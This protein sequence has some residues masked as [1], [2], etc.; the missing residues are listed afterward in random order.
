[1]ECP[2]CHK[3]IPDESTVCPSCHK[4]LSL[5]CP[6]CRTVGHSSVCDN[7][8]Y[9]I[10]ERCSKCGHTVSTNSKKCKCGFQVLTSIA[11]QE[12]EADEFA[13]VTVNF[14]GLKQVRKSLASKELFDKFKIKLK[15]LLISQFKNLDGNV[16]S[17]GDTYVIN[18]NKELSFQTSSAKAV[19]TALKLVNAFTSLNMKVIE[20]FGVLLKMHLTIIKKSAEELLENKKYKTNVKPLIINK[21]E[22]KYLRGTQI[23]LDEFVQDVISKEYKTDSLYTVEENGKTIVFYEIKLDN[24]VL[25][26]DKNIEEVEMVNQEKH[27]AI[28]HSDNNAD[29]NVN[30][31][32]IFD[33]KAKCNFQNSASIDVLSKLSDKNIIA[34]KGSPDLELETS[35]IV[36]YYR[37][38]GRKVLRVVCTEE[39]NYRPWGVLEEIFRQ[40]YNLS[41]YNKLIP[42]DL[43][44]QYFPE[45]VNLVQ[46]K[47]RKASTPEDARFAYIDDFVRF[48]SIIKDT[49]VIIDGFEHADDTTLQAIELYFDNY[50]KVK[51]NFI[52]ITNEEISVHSKI[53]SLL[54]TSLYKEINLQKNK[55]ENLISDIKDD[56][57]DFI[58]SF[59]YE[60]IKSCFKGSKL[61]FDNAINYLKEHD[62]LI[63]FEGKLLVKNNDSVFLPSELSELI[64]SRLK[65]LSK[66]Q[67]ASMVLAF[68]VLINPR[69][70]YEFLQLLGIQDL[71]SSLKILEEAGFVY[72][73]NNCVFLNNAPLFRSVIISSLKKNVTEFLSKTILA[74]VGQGLDN[75]TTL[76][77][78]GKIGLLKDEYLLLWK[79]A[80]FAIDTG[81]YD[82][83]LKNTM[84]FMKLIDYIKGNIPD[85][86]IENH[87]KDVYNNILSALFSYS[88]EKIYDIEQILI[89]DAEKKDDK[90]NLVK[91]S[92]LMLQGALLSGKFSDASVFLNNIFKNMQNPKFLV[93]GVINTKFLLLSLINIEISFNLG[94]Y[95]SCIDIANE[96]LD[97]LTPEI[98]KKIKPVN[99]SLNL[100]AEHL[101]ETFRLAAIAH[102]LSSGNAIEVFLDKIKIS[103]GEE[104]PDKGSLIAVKNF[105]AGKDYDIEN[106]E[107]APAFSK[108]IYLILQEFSEQNINWKNFAQNIYQAKLLASDINQ[109]MLKEFCE[110]LIAY[111]YAK[112]EVYKKAENIFKDI[113][114]KS[115]ACANINVL[116]F[117]KYFYAELK[118]QKGEYES[119][120]LMINDSISFINSNV[121]KA[122]IMLALYRYLL[123]KTVKSSGLNF[124]DTESEMQNL[125]KLLPNGE[126][127]GIIKI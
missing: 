23:V 2:K 92:N 95:K 93:D 30:D 69:L 124:I 57:S 66:K 33:I 80:R 118:L 34:I 15:N 18:F 68:L 32:N 39:M 108:I 42:K 127:S 28:A 73:D 19:R 54:R 37:L 47:S 16:I 25:P 11:F 103:L 109:L 74:R 60:K 77:L 7:C 56:A 1:M 38:K 17:Y 83:Y 91:L 50:K 100:F 75:T 117:A 64:K 26:P 3:N 51:T 6:N 101:A 72:C 41:P 49:V 79:N 24:Y 106:I 105:I 107:D 20:E 40:Y 53:K 121:P 5:V 122:I 97:I 59:Y 82:S 52:F 8:G 46:N 116:L 87:K 13:A 126:L 115:E 14:D 63:S 89:A 10:L 98:I 45:L 22:K 35:E 78:M 36:N 94:D 90:T 104:L 85:E 81:D 120:L 111:A 44:V 125:S 112:C 84:G 58:S 12:C 76:L 86:D 96:I 114:D 70:D 48:L 113:I 102:I 43:N 71:T 67:D 62:V 31:F 27:E 55:I 88:P 4:V 123:I 110:L 29:E 119:A 21:N 65:I 99:F 61:Y 9:I